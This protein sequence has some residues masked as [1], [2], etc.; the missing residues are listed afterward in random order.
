MLPRV[1]SM[2]YFLFFLTAELGSWLG[3]SG[4][5]FKD[6]VSEVDLIG[7]RGGVRVLWYPVNHSLACQQDS[8]AL[9]CSLT[10]C[11]MV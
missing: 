8:P 6:P 11:V 10:V 7:A 3:L 2:P 1:P 4:Q 5:C 9:M